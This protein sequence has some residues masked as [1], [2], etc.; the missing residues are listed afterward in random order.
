LGPIEVGQAVLTS[1]GDMPP[2]A[3]ALIHA[4]AMGFTERTQIYASPETVS[5]AT[6][7]ALELCA[8]NRLASVTIPALGTGVGGLEIEAAAAAMA[9]ALRAFLADNPDSLDRVRFVVTNDERRGTFA[10]ALGVEST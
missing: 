4:A 9:A 1:A 10:S 2:P 5:A 3:R 6:T 7:Q 8:R